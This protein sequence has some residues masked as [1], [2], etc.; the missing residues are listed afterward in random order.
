MILSP[1]K[2]TLKRWYA[3]F[4]T[5]KNGYSLNRTLQ[6][7][8]I[9]GLM[10]TGKVIDLG[11]GAHTSYGHLLNIQGDLESVNLSTDIA[12]TYVADLNE[13]LPIDDQL[14][15]AA[16]SF[17]TLE[18]I[19]KDE[20]ALSEIHRILKP[21]GILHIMVPFYFRVHEDPYTKDYHRHTANGWISLLERT[22]FNN[23]QIEP[24]AFGVLSS[25]YSTIENLMPNF[26]G[27]RGITKNTAMLL[28]VLL[29]T[30]LPRT[31]TYHEVLP[32]TY[33]I[34]CKKN[35]L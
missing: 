12:P 7:D 5:N 6:Y 28:D 10:L 23:I 11:G 13:P 19:A 30:I 20:V 18:H 27:I 34:T 4:Q 33:Y 31:K 29:A 35:V 9:R 1:A 8:R 2:P 3:L 14:F 21:D 32:L 17:N 25:A 22:N 26:L 16:I 24:L 15:D